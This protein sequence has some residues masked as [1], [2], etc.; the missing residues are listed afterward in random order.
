MPYIF[1]REAIHTVVHILNRG[2]LRVNG[3]KTPYHMWK[4]K[5]A[6]VKHFKVFG[7]KCYIKR[8]EEDLGKFHFRSDEDF[9]LDTHV[10][11]GTH[12]IQ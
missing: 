1:W 5:P 9:F 7:N 4:G 8:E 6:I 2:Q 12:M 10:Q 11:Q 3:D